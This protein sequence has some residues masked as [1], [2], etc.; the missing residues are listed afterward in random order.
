M[1]ERPEAFFR[2]PYV[3]HRGWLGVFL[4]AG[5]SERELEGLLIEAHRQA[6]P[7]RLRAALDA[8]ARG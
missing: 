4:D 1:A 6:C 8:T 5:L 3:G 7:A 2:P